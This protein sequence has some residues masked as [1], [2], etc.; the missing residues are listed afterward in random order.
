MQGGGGKFFKIL[1]P[2]GGVGGGPHARL[3]GAFDGEKLFC[4][5][6]IAFVATSST[7]SRSKPEFFPHFFLR[8]KKRS[9]RKSPQGVRGSIPAPLLDYPP[10]PSAARNG[11]FSE[12]L[13]SMPS[14]AEAE[15]CVRSSSSGL[16]RSGP[17]LSDFADRGT[18]F[19]ASRI[20]ALDAARIMSGLAR[21]G[22]LWL[23]SVRRDVTSGMP[24]PPRGPR[25]PPI[26]PPKN[27]FKIP[28]VDGT[29]GGLCV[30]LYSQK[31][32]TFRF[33]KEFSP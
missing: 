1:L 26:F 31:E 16:V 15:R 27:F 4:F 8:K 25:F 18:V 29:E 11:H 12:A 6:K 23:V 10:H 17:V 7:V 24:W 28:K 3:C 13:P 14:R 33:R 22:I 9:Q 19:Y 2:R 30:I 32:H 21:A 5:G 20:P